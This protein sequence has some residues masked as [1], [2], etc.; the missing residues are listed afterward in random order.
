MNTKIKDL[1][2][3]VENEIKVNLHVT[4]LPDQSLVYKKYRIKKTKNNTWEL[5]QIK[6]SDIISYF[7]T[8]SSA[9]LAAKFYDNQYFNK[10]IEIKELDRK[11]ISNLV[12]IEIY[13]TR[14]NSNIDYEKRLLFEIKLDMCQRRYSHCKKEIAGRLKTEF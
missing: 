14:L 12:D 11:L 9:L 4:I 8:K 6:S 10:F 13:K 3:F 5:K 1:K 7:N 2:K